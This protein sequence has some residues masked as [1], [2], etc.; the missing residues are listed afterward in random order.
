MPMT[1]NTH[2]FTK[3]RQ[4]IRTTAMVT[5]GTIMASGCFSWGHRGQPSRRENR[6]ITRHPHY[7]GGS[8]T[9]RWP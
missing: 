2:L 9:V 7:C 5:N 4:Q 8:G 6:A 3:A 1:S